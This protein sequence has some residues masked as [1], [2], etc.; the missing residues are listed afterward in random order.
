MVGAFSLFDD[1]NRALNVFRLTVLALNDEHERADFYYRRAL[2][3]RRF[4]SLQ[5]KKSSITPKYLQVDPYDTTTLFAYAVFLESIERFVVCSLPTPAVTTRFLHNNRLAEAEMY[6]I[7][8]LEID[9]FNDHCLQA[10]GYF[11]EDKLKDSETAEQFYNVA[12][13]VRQAKIRA[14]VKAV[15]PV[16][17]LFEH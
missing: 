12:S 13:H 1:C 9:P 2:E 17:E 7:G 3:V 11:I 10:Y 14:N 5:K 15:E 6:Y 8:C 16:D 4:L